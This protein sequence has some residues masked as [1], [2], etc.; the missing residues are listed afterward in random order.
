[1]SERIVS[2]AVKIAGVNAIFSSPPPARHHDVMHA[3]AAE[4]EYYDGR[5]W[6]Q[7]FLTSSGRFV[8]RIEACKIADKAGQ[9]NIVRP[10][11][12]PDYELFSED[13]W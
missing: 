11:T 3:V 7:G 10:K 12:N 5:Q 8:D 1:M 2:A 4:I 13:L 6:F 9:L